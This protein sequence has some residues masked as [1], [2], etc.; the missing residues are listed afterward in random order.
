M[1]SLCERYNT[2]L[3]VM[4]TI[5]PTEKCYFHDF[6]F[7]AITRQ[8]S[9]TQSRHPPGGSLGCSEECDEDGC[10]EPLPLLFPVLPPLTILKKLLKTPP[11]PAPLP[12]ALPLAVELPEPAR[13]WGDPGPALGGRGPFE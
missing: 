6:P 1:P 9:Q 3:H 11:P 7:S 12:L 10:E 2:D 8:Y 13:L 4:Q 5:H